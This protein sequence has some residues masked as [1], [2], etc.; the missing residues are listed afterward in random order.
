MRQVFTLVFL[1]FLMPHVANGSAQVVQFLVHADEKTDITRLFPGAY[2]DF[3]WNGIYV[4]SI[5]TTEPESLIR[6][7]RQTLA[8]NTNVV[9]SLVLP[10][11]LE[12]ST[13]KWLASNLVWVALLVLICISGCACGGGLVLQCFNARRAIYR[14]Q[15]V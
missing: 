3:T 10:Y 2:V 1:S 5:W 8:E 6:S 14:P 11:T 9:Q 15:R 4:V 7:I 12:V 13:Q